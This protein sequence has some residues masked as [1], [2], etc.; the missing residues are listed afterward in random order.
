[1]EESIR[2]IIRGFKAFRK[3]CFIENP[4]LFQR[5][6]KGQTAKILV[7][8]C[9]DSRVDPAIIMQSDPGDIFVVRNVANLV[10]PYDPDTHYHGV[11][12]ALEYAVR[13][14]EVEHIIVMGHSD[15]GGIKTL[16]TSDHERLSSEFIG[17]WLSI[18]LPAK[19]EVLE[20][21]GNASP[22][23]QQCACE[24]ASLLLTMENLLSFP[25]IRE[26]TEN[27]RLKLHAWYFNIGKGHLYGYDSDQEAF[28]QIK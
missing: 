28:M 11:S 1:M 8:A 7:I 15:C 25:W 21:L 12:A 18:A 3:N 14:L 22:E 16:M 6:N 4:E 5:L 20:K 27:G 9:S 19:K 10:P 2:K 23:V 24:E 26:R 17:Q 13:M